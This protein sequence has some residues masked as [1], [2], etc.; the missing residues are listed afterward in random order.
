MTTTIDHHQRRLQILTKAFA[1]FAEEGYT[2]VTYQK[3]A[4]RCG[5]S[6]TAIY[7]YFQNKE[8]MFLYAVKLATD[9]LTTLIENTLRHHE[10]TSLEKLVRVLRVTVRLLADNRIF[11][12]VILDYVLTQKQHGKDIRRQVRRRTFGLKHLLMRLL[13][14]ASVAEELRICQIETAVHHLYGLLESFILNL[15]VTNILDE[16]DYLDLIDGYIAQLKGGA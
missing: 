7:K 13:R 6:R 8:E 3:V 9:N 15:T 5:I 14:E 4:D 16:K 10:G 1:L 12:T 2:G 11:L